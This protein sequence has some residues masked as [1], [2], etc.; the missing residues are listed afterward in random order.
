LLQNLLLQYWNH[1]AFR[2][3]Q[4]EI[5]TAVMAGRDTFALLP[6]GGGKSVCYQLPAIAQEGF[7][8]V[9][10]PLIALMQDQ[11]MQLNQKGIEAAFIHSGMQARQVS[12]MLYKTTAGAFKLVYVAPERLQSEVFLDYMQDFKL[13]LIAVDE[14][15]C[16]S[17]WGH[18]FRPAYRKIDV[19]RDHFPQ[20]PVLALTASATA[21]VQEDIMQ[22]LRFRDPAIFRQSIV[23]SN[24]YYHIRYTEN[25]PA[26]TAN[27]FTSVKGSGIVYCRSRKRCVET[28]MQLKSESIDTGVYHAGLLKEEREQAQKAW[29]DSH[30]K[31]MCATTAFG[32]GINKP[33]VRTV[34]HYDAPEHLEAYYQEAGRAGRDGA[35]AH[36]ILLYDHKDILRLQESV[37]INY[38]PESYIRDIY[39]LVGDYLRMPVGKGFEEL[40]S[41]DAVAFAHK[42]QLETLKALSAIRL[43]DREGFW[44]WNENVN[45]QTWVQ[46][47]TDRK[48]LNYLEQS[49]PALSYVA[50]GLLRLYGSIF[51]YPT[52][53]REFEVSKLLRIE[54]PQ[55][56]R[57]LQRLASL[58]V[59][60]YQPATAGGTLYWMHNRLPPAHLRLDMTHINRLRKAQA[61]RVQAMT[62]Y[63]QANDTCRNILLSRYFGE[64]EGEACGGCDVCKKEQQQEEVGQDQKERILALIRKRQETTVQE[65]TTHFPDIA[66]GSIIAYIR[67]LHD[68][69][70]CRV[71]PTGIIFAT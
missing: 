48:T 46:F 23:R 41:F 17:Q 66:P 51:H 52:A 69:S 19:L 25:K 7:C 28:A 49:D 58:G 33:D 61:E 29:T 42:F 65:L 18:D 20:V 5:I 14:A 71:Y 68:E 44:Q 47:T 9:V 38:P 21:Q 1:T 37:E 24:L 30:S 32:M 16:I 54:K 31:V 26:D 53:I 2:P 13:N 60:D 55:L 27:V 10:S 56:D 40:Q 8:L 62:D 43:L 36:A 70:L 3:L 4:E 39:H 34:L 64:L 15:H 57:A 67:L 35:K 45:M 12:D 63:L 50:T 11:V 6:T 22:Q 59:I